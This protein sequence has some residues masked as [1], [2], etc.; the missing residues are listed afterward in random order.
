MTELDELYVMARRVLLDALDAL[1]VHR[2]AIVSRAR[3]GERD[4]ERRTTCSNCRAVEPNHATPASPP[5]IVA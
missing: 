5:G 3:F 4:D 2:D 1:G